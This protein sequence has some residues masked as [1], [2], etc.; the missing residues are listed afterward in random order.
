M[1]QNIPNIFR[2]IKTVVYILKLKAVFLKLINN[3]SSL[4]KVIHDRDRVWVSDPIEK[5]YRTLK[6][7]FNRISKPVHVPQKYI[8]MRR[9]FNSLLSVLKCGQIQSFVFAVLHN[10][11]RNTKDSME[12]SLLPITLRD[13]FTIFP[14]SF[15]FVHSFIRAT[16]ICS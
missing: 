6:T 5:I 12:G 3:W 13:L 16:R 14:R 15:D 8:A 2:W 10:T 11:R 7:V 9:F 4:N 1:K